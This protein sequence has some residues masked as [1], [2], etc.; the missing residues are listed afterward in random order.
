MLI[1]RCSSRLQ[2]Y[3]DGHSQRHYAGLGHRDRLAHLTGCFWYIHLAY[4]ADSVTSWLTIAVSIEF[5]L[6]IFGVVVAYWIE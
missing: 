4:L 1:D 2:R 6:N 5:T 3:R